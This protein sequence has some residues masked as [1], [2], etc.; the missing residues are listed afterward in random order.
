MTSKPRIAPRELHE[1]DQLG[2][3]RPSDAGGAVVQPR[4]LDVM[5][6]IR[7]RMDAGPIAERDP[8]A[9][10]RCRRAVPSI[11]SADHADARIVQWTKRAAGRCLPRRIAP[12]NALPD[13]T[14]GTHQLH[15]I[16]LGRNCDRPSL[17]GRIRS[18]QLGGLPALCNNRELVQQHP[19]DAKRIRLNGV[20]ADHGLSHLERGANQIRAPQLAAI[21]PDQHQL[22]AVD[23]ERRCAMGRANRR[24]APDH[25]SGRREP[26]DRGSHRGVTTSPDG[27]AIART[28]PAWSPCT[29]P[30]NCVPF[31]LQPVQ[32]GSSATGGVPGSLG[33]GLADEKQAEMLSAII[34]I[35]IFFMNRI[36]T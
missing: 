28:A 9:V 26:R 29:S 27:R 34:M 32:R 10:A 31:M 7:A 8:R 14:A 16:V 13:R 19:I 18:A 30:V 33:A 11:V 15:L 6:A 2:N 17:A 23:R 36:V 24:S 21:G 5:P 22:A 12:A 3:P 25:R 20:E 1:V 35:I 4:G